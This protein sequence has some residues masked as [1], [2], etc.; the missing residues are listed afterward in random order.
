VLA[1]G[2]GL[3][4]EVATIKIYNIYDLLLG[5]EVRKF[6]VDQGSNLNGDLFYVYPGQETGVI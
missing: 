3:T 6:I 4:P 1:L 5:E 2:S